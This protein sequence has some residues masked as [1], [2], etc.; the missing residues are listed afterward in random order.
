MSEIELA[1]CTL[2]KKPM[3][4]GM[5]GTLLKGRGYSAS[6][7]LKHIASKVPG[8]AV[9]QVEGDTVIAPEQYIGQT[10]DGAVPAYHVALPKILVDFINAQDELVRPLLKV[11]MEYLTNRIFLQE[12]PPVDIYT[13]GSCISATK[14]GG[15]AVVFPEKTLSGNFIRTTSMRAELW[16]IA[17]ALENTTYHAVIHTDCQYAIHAIQK[18]K[19]S[20][21]DDLVQHIRGMLQ[22]RNVIFQWVKGH[23]G[24]PGNEAA[25][26]EACRQAH[27]SSSNKDLG[28]EEQRAREKLKKQTNPVAPES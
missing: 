5:L 24:T 2:V 6:G 17:M 7:K 25:H 18:G 21:N 20:V 27:M 9:Y 15:W 10:P 16:A 11:P 22:S 28:Y 4:L 12:Q 19:R 3:T 8:F 1:I 23:M 13:D 14:V 26:K